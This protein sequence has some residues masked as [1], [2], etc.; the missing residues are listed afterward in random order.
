MRAGDHRPAFGIPSGVVET[1]RAGTAARTA[2]RRLIPRPT[3]RSITANNGCRC[4]AAAADAAPFRCRFTNRTAGVTS[5]RRRFRL[6][7]GSDCAVPPLAGPPLAGPPRAGPCLAGPGRGQA[8]AT[9]V[10]AI[11]P[12]TDRQGPHV[13]C[14][15]RRQG[16]LSSGRPAL[17]PAPGTPCPYR[18]SSEAPAA[19]RPLRDAL[20]SR[21]SRRCGRPDPGGPLPDA[22]RAML[23]RRRTKAPAAPAAKAAHGQHGAEASAGAPP[24]VQAKDVTGAGAGGIDPFGRIDGN[25]GPTDPAASRGAVAAAVTTSGAG[26]PGLAIQTA[27]LTAD[28]PHVTR[29]ATRTA[30]ADASSPPALLSPA[31]ASPAPSPSSAVP[32]PDADANSDADAQTLQTAG[33]LKRLAETVRQSSQTL[34]PSVAIVLPPSPLAQQPP[35]LAEVETSSLHSLR[36]SPAD[37]S[38]AEPRS[39]ATPTTL[40]GHVDAAAA[41]AAATAAAHAV[42]PSL[43]AQ[44]SAALTAPCT[45]AAAAAAKDPLAVATEGPTPTAASPA[46]D[47]AARPALTVRVSLASPATPARSSVTDRYP[48]QPPS[49]DRAPLVGVASWEWA[50][51]RYAYEVQHPHAS[52]EAFTRVAQ[53]NFV[54]QLHEVI[55]VTPTSP[56]GI[57]RPSDVPLMRRGTIRASASSRYVATA[58]VAGSD[59]GTATPGAASDARQRPVRSL[60]DLS[61]NDAAASDAAVAD[62]AVPADRR[63]PSP[64]LAAAPAAVAEDAAAAS[65][66]ADAARPIETGLPV[67]SADEAEAP[68]LVAP[69]PWAAPGA[70]PSWPPIPASPRAASPMPALVSAA[71]IPASPPNEA[72]SRPQTPAALAVEGPIEAA[73][74]DGMGFVMDA[75]AIHDLAMMLVGQQ[76]QQQAAEAEAAADL[77][78]ARVEADASADAVPAAEAEN[79]RLTGVHRSFVAPPD[80]PYHRQRRTSVAVDDAGRGH[81]E[82]LS[83]HGSGDELLFHR[84]GALQPRRVISNSCRSPAA[85]DE[86]QLTPSLSADSLDR[87]A[88]TTVSPTATASRTTGATPASVSPPRPAASLPSASTEALDREMGFGA[89]KFAKLKNST[90]LLSRLPKP[91]R[92]FRSQPDAVTP[93]PMLAA[94]PVSEAAAAA[95]SKRRLP[96]LPGIR[97]M[98]STSSLR[99]E[100]HPTSASTSATSVAAS[101][102]PVSPTAELE[103]EVARLRDALKALKNHSHVAAVQNDVLR[104]QLAREQAKTT[105]ANP[106]AAEAAM[107]LHAQHKLA[108]QQERE[109]Y[110][111]LLD[112]NHHLASQIQHLETTLKAKDREIHGAQA[113]RFANEAAATKKQIRDLQRQVTEKDKQLTRT[114]TALE[115]ALAQRAKL[116]KDIDLLRAQSHPVWRPG[117][118]KPPAEVALAPVAATA[119]AA[120]T[121]A[122]QPV[123]RRP[124]LPRLLRTPEVR[125]RATLAHASP[126]GEPLDPALDADADADADS[127]AHSHHTG[128]GDASSHGRETAGPGTSKLP[129]RMFSR[130]HGKA[131]ETDAAQAAAGLRSRRG[132]PAVPAAHDLPAGTAPTRRRS[133]LAARPSAAEAAVATSTP[134]AAA[135]RAR[136]VSEPP[137]RQPSEPDDALLED[138][139]SPLHSASLAGDDPRLKILRTKLEYKIW[140]EQ[141]QERLEQEKHQPQ[142]QQPSEARG[143]AGNRM[144]RAAAAIL[145][146]DA[147]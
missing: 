104:R 137:R 72:T 25:S 21:R 126:A 63:P 26:G 131:S 87:A 134:G 71:A 74:E 23:F 65:S 22:G 34:H 78:P 122:R 27:A 10:H 96:K 120:T 3:D 98:L 136:V 24:S 2:P 116:E 9:R 47:T 64:L 138:A 119:A 118:P 35:M 79:A 69:T 7:A 139:P 80:A 121:V 50:P 77:P 110:V 54:D 11:R 18:G 5:E 82:S 113:T 107:H 4:N 117:Q 143:R 101:A 75:D 60:N 66:N 68:L 133:Q 36:R 145:G 112:D 106:G 127:L 84:H 39:P 15:H 57:L 32:E 99:R 132:A 8:A 130:G 1:A 49:P 124:T 97:A 28:A 144:H 55:D 58:A 37:R 17:R 94:A 59:S 33:A 135:P 95:S 13:A 38:P 48:V 44:V 103:A 6:R 108:L 141:Q 85:S 51:D 42:A 90:S 61:R 109:R 30:S 140:V 62:D 52:L 14:P 81:A 45:A 125:R 70:P 12:A 16:S 43:S 83:S 19:R 123:L 128:D 88:T 86:G 29:P 114:A 91:H 31:A 129:T 100:M 56:T 89:S 76:T 115:Q 73:A 102:A 147:S 46:A 41:A 67:G 92:A 20:A 146:R 142:D 93:A 105:K 40:D 111:R 53:Q